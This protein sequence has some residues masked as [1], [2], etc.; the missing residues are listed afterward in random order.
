MWNH[1]DLAI[2]LIPI[3]PGRKSLFNLQSTNV[4]KYGLPAEVKFCRSC[5]ISNQRPS[6]SIEFI[7]DGVKPKRVI[8]FDE[9]GVCDACRVK[10]QKQSIDW[11]AREQELRELC[12]DIDALTAI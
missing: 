4:T 1:A 12:K 10:D 9:S 2:I 6:S 11:S 8:N 7:N 5:V 3:H